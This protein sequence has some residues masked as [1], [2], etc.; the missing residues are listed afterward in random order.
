MKKVMLLGD[1]IRISYMETVKRLLTDEAEVWGPPDNCRFVKYTLWNIGDWL[2]ACGKPD[3][4]HWNNGIWDIY[5][6]NDH[7]G[8]FTPLDEYITYLERTLAELR[9]TGAAIIWATT[10][11]ARPGL[12]TCSNDV[13]D[14]YNAEAVA[15]MRWRKVEI[16]DL[17]AL[18]R[19]DLDR[20]ISEDKVHL[21]E[22]GIAACGRQVADIVRARL[23]DGA[24]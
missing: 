15:F 14:Q 6:Q 23:Q 10:T 7:L 11:P 1:S 18:L 9:R 21:S 5:L 19:P 17:N 20:Y 12:A 3:V 4:I 16:N 24:V 2:T 13:I 22:A 8:V